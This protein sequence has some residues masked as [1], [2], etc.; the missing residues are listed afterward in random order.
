MD[1]ER[2]IWKLFQSHLHLGRLHH[3]I[4]LLV[5]TDLQY[6]LITVAS[7][8]LRH[9]SYDGSDFQREISAKIWSCVDHLVSLYVG[10]NCSMAL[11]KK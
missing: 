10:P 1:H 8:L 6:Q 5:A 2:C 9:C 7:N 11:S 3:L 4:F